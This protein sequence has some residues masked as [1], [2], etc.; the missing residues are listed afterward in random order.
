VPRTLS[1]D[2]GLKRVGLA[3]SDESGSFVFPHDV[4]HVNDPADA[5]EP[6]ANL[7]RAESIEQIVIGLPLNMDGT[8]GPQARIVVAWGK[9][10]HIATGIS[11]VYV[12]ERLS[13]FDAEQTLIGQQRAGRKLTRD[14]KKDRLDALAAATFL[15]AFLD[16]QLAPIDV[17]AV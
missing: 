3:I 15:R 16:G 8:V 11:P 14:Q 4:L 6:I 13:S 7:V 9:A 2:H 12:D 1:I 10:I 17:S 5:I